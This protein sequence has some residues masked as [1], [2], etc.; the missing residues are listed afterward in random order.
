MNMKNV[1]LTLILCAFSAMYAQAQIAKPVAGNRLV[2][3]RAAGLANLGGGLNQQ[4]G[5][6]MLRIFK[7]DMTAHRWAVD[8][9][10]TFDNERTD[11]K[12]TLDN[13]SLN[14]GMENHMA[15]SKR[16][17]TYWGYDAGLSATSNFDNIGVQGGLFTGFDF[18]IAD[19]LYL[20]S[21]LGYRLRINIDPFQL[22]FP[23]TGINASLKM[24]YR[25]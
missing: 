7:S 6:A 1:L 21:E 23:G 10:L 5:G 20:G 17:S 2:E 18:Y 3:M 19:G 13:I 8:M 22:Q 25:L 16:M 14:W 4:Y 11:D 12:F 24:G 9:G 15:G